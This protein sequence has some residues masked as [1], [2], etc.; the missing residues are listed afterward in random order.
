MNSIWRWSRLV[1]LSMGVGLWP[2][3]AAW[4][5]P[6]ADACALL[7]RADAEAAFAPRTFGP[8]KLGPVVV[9]V[10]EK[11]AAWLAAV[12][13]CTVTSTEA[14]ARD[15]LAIGLKLR[16]APSDTTGV[17][18]AQAREGAVKLKATPVE[19]A[20]LGEGA[21]W[22]NLGSSAR[23]MVQ[24]NVF[25]GQREWLIFSASGKGLDV[26][27]AVEGLRKVALAVAARP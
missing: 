2:A 7:R 22:V 3:A 5:A 13:D 6:A 25:R 18:P 11:N 24:L 21:Y 10:T 15:R 9:K 1:I 20:G 26:A 16:R 27:A 17:T 14:A 23:P 8:G 12:T 4:A 19:V